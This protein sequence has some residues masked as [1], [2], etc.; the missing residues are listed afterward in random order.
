MDLFWEQGYES[1]SL[2]DLVETT[3]VNRVSLYREF[4]DKRGL[5]L[6]CLDRYT[7]C[8]AADVF[9]PLYAD[10]ADLNTIVAWF[11]ERGKGQVDAGFEC[12]MMAKAA[13]DDVADPEVA[14]RVRAYAA[15]SVDAFTTALTTARDRGQLPSDLEPVDVARML[16]SLG[17]G[18]TV[19]ARSLRCAQSAGRAVFTALDLLSSAQCDTD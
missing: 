12:C 6:A 13:V 7:A 17:V 19:L 9:A 11:E 16:F 5:Y 18:A 15:R 8:V 1:T 10:D 4:G 2:S 3:G 14:A